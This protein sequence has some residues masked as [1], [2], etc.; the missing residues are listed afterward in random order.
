M[1]PQ[2]SPYPPPSQPV[3]GYPPRPPTNGLGIAGFVC[4]LMGVLLFWIPLLG[5]GLAIVGL[6]LGT[7]GYTNGGRAGAPTGL[8]LS[9]AILGGVG[10]FLFL[11]M[12]LLTASG[13][14]L[15]S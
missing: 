6:V 15:W 8:A 12:A 1:H 4:G 3:W 11:I 9:G 7:V 2:Q 10:L 14:G 5:V 13:A